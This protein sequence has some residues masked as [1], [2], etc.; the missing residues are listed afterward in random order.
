[1]TDSY[2][3]LRCSVCCAD[4]L[5]CD[6]P[7]LTKMELAR[8]QQRLAAVEQERE[9][10]LAANRVLTDVTEQRRAERDQLRRE[11]EAL[12]GVVD[13]VRRFLAAR[14]EVSGMD[15]YMYDDMAVVTM[16]A[17]V[18]ALDAASTVQREWCNRHREFVVSG[19]EHHHDDCPLS[20]H[21][22]TGQASDTAS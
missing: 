17:A 19:F 5:A 11:N 1:M 12:R 20:A 8:L 4:N 9:R 21:A 3:D 13:A 10:L 22:S 16:E 15:V 2:W 18:A 14:E 7:E 6:T